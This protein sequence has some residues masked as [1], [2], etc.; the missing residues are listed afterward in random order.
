VAHIPMMRELLQFTAHIDTRA[1]VCG[2]II[3]AGFGGLKAIVR[4]GL[5]ALVG[6][7]L[8]HALQGGG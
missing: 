7:C 4:I 6:C 1:I 5:A 2:R 8:D 3:Q